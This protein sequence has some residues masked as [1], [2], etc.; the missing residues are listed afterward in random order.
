M[1]ELI[2]SAILLFAMAFVN[3]AGLT[4][5]IRLPENT[6]EK[7]LRLCGESLWDG[8]LGDVMTSVDGTTSSF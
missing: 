5:G 6:S 4:F 2:T 1:S 7:D 8:E 3:N